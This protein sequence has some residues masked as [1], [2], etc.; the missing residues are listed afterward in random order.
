MSGRRKAQDEQGGKSRQAGGGLGSAWGLLCGVPVAAGLLA[1]VHL[2]PSFEGTLLRR[3]VSHPIE[4]VEVVVIFCAGFLLL[5]KVLGCR[6]QRRAARAALLPPWDGRAQPVSEATAL[7][8]E[9]GR[10]P[11]R[12]RDSWAGRRVAAVLDFVCRRQS[13]AELDD[14][15]RTLSD[16]DALAMGSSYKLIGLMNW[17]L[18]ILG[19]LGTV[20][21]IAESVAGVTPEKL[22][23]SISEV[24]GGLALAFD[25]TGLALMLTMITMP[26]TTLAERR[27]EA[28]LA[29]VDRLIDLQLA[30]R[31]ERVDG[32]SEPLLAAVRANADVLLRATEEV[33]R[34]QAEVWANTLAET[35]GRRRAAEAEQQE[36]FTAALEAA[37]GRTLAVHEERLATLQREAEAGTAAVLAPLAELSASLWQQHAAMLPVS[38]G[39]QAMTAALARLQEDE[40]RL[41][42]Q[43]RLLQQNLSALAS[44]GSFEQAVHSLTAAVHLLTARGAGAWRVLGE[45]GPRAA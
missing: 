25:T 31:F 43:Q 8:A 2:E 10:L 27:E 17:S 22:E 44:A 1:L 7:L 16:N 33:V 28:V 12:L 32:A 14:H 20:L 26:L 35:E 23:T 9:V 30:H 38:E 40:G 42:R 41:L 15:L 5:S 37:L 19:F 39:L 3:Y 36:R 29:E 4:W 13:A 24:T 11:R 18:P 34:R 45:E 21:G 6:A